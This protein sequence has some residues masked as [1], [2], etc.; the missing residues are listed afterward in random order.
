MKIMKNIN[1]NKDNDLKSE[2]V[3]ILSMGGSIIALQ[4]CKEYKCSMCG[5]IIKSEKEKPVE[6]AQ[7]CT[8]F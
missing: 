2:D 5:Q 6:H 3:P 4:N 7:I 1:L 8:G